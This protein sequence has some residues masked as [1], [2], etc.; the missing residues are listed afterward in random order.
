MSG[1]KLKC[2]TRQFIWLNEVIIIILAIQQFKR[3]YPPGLDAGSN[4][5]AYYAYLPAARK[6][7]ENGWG[8]LF[9]DPFSATVTPLSYLWPALWRADVLTISWANGVLFVFSTLIMWHAGRKLGGWVGATVAALLMIY[10]PSITSFMPKVLTE[11][12]YLFGLMLFNWSLIELLLRSESTRRRWVVLGSI[13]LTITLLSRPVLQGLVVAGI[14][15]ALLVMAV[16][17]VHAWRPCLRKILILLIVSGILPIAVIIKNGVQF[18]LWGIATGGGAALYYGVNPLRLGHEPAYMGFSYDI[19]DTVSAA[20][21]AAA[22]NFLNKTADRIERAIGINIL[23]NTK[24]QDLLHFFGYKIRSWLFYSAPELKI[25]GSLRKLRLFEWLCII[26]GAMV[27]LL[28]L[29]KIGDS[30]QPPV[31]HRQLWLVVVLLGAAVIAMLAQLTPLLYN[32]RYNAGFL[33]PWLLLLTAA[34]VGSLL[35]AWR[36]PHDWGWRSP[37][38]RQLMVLPVLAGLA[39]VFAN[40][41]TRHETLPIDP[42]RLGPVA[43]VLDTNDI[44]PAIAD[45]LA[46]G[47]QHWR[48]QEHAATLEIPLHKVPYPAMDFHDGIWRFHMRVS[49]AQPKRCRSVTLKVEHPGDDVGWPPPVLPIIADGQWHTYALY[50]NHIL[51]PMRPGKLQLTLYCPPGT[52]ITWGGAQLLRS[53]MPEAARA[54]WQRG[55]GINSYTPSPW[56]AFTE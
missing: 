44:G 33:E 5:D 18:D 20:D 49:A 2:G 19:V 4:S 40:W 37:R 14:V 43:P 6:L 27:W 16:P 21:P 17:R 23:Q 9:N 10:N 56:A 51:R 31:Q 11:P 36:T 50:G 55:V 53:T 48:L 34:A 52:E 41:S 39:L 32:T 22:G 15:L 35:P 30:S 8:F 42:E 7:I 46:V 3:Y 28:C 25:E 47:P 54:F 13:G 12:L 26:S 38:W 29:R 1:L 24:S 45:A